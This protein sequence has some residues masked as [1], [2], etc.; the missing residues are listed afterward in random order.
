MTVR[1]ITESLEGARPTRNS[2]G[3]YEVVLITPGRG[4]SGMY[5]EEALRESGPQAWPKGT[6]SYVNHLRADEVRD[7]LKLIGYLVE[8]ARYKDG[9]GLVSRMKP[10]SKWAEWVDEVAPVV[11]MSISAMSTGREEV[12]EG[13]PTWVVE[14]LIPDIQNTVDLV[15]YAGRGGRIAEALYES[16]AATVTP[17]ANAPEKTSKEANTM[18]LEDEVKTLVSTVE[19]LVAA[20]T[21]Q[22]DAAQAATESQTSAADIASKAAEATVLV[23]SAEVPT[24]VKTRLIES[25]KAGNFDV[26]KHIDEA[27]ALRA[28]VLAEQEAAAKKADETA[29]ANGVVYTSTVR[30]SD[31]SIETPKG[32]N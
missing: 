9:V 15:S 8:D 19:G 25:I 16:A 3:T 31:E 12:I 10:I 5:S 6:H 18:A 14:S 20:L 17:E 2:D 30:K 22:N 21:A 11:G 32:W 28:E 24:S 13:Q 4:S 7:P 26:Q 1:K 29:A 23:E 27:Q